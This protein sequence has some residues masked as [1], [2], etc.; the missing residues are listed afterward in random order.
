MGSHNLIIPR[1]IDS[2]MHYEALP[3][4]LTSCDI[5]NLCNLIDARSKLVSRGVIRTGLFRIGFGL[6]LLVC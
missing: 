6:D 1:I 4:R 2:K 5:E 3:C